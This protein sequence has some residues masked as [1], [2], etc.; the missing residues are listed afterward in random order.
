MTYKCKYLYGP[1]DGKLQ[2]IQY[3]NISR[4]KIRLFLWVFKSRR[5]INTL[6]SYNKE[7]FY[8]QVYA[9]KLVNVSVWP[10]VRR[11]TTKTGSIWKEMLYFL[12]QQR[13]KGII[14][15][16]HLRAVVWFLG[17]FNN[18]TLQHNKYQPL[19]GIYFYKVRVFI[20]FIVSISYLRKISTL[21]GWD[22]YGHLVV[23]DCRRLSTMKYTEKLWPTF[24]IKSEL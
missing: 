5:G 17:T 2:Q 18:M 3:N 24:W 19:T 1:I 21:L 12:K 8:I 16:K 7:I 6:T 23:G 22:V 20:L 4:Y 14:K 13:Q 15:I 10:V 9:R 11:Q